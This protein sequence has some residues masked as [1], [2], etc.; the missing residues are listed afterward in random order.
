MN[1]NIRSI[2]RSVH[3]CDSHKMIGKHLFRVICILLC[4][5]ISLS[6]SEIENK[7]NT[8]NVL[9]TIFPP[10]TQFD[11]SSGCVG[12]IEIFSL[13]TIAK[14]LKLNLNLTKTSDLKRIPGC[15]LKYRFIILFYSSLIKL[16]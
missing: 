15:E 1:K 4:F 14:K 11:K 8:V 9:A 16:K 12:G 6:Y 13:K 2:Y 10:F 5:I 7:T 3:S